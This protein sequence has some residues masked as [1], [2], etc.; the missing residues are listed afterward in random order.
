MTQ[1]ILFNKP[2]Q[3]LSQFTCNESD[4]ETLASFIK[5]PGVYAAGRLDYDSEGLLL[6]T[7]NGQLQH[8]IAH[9]KHKSVKTYWA[10]V[11]GTPTQDQIQQLC[12]GVMLKDGI[13][14]PAQVKAMDEPDIWKRVPPIR[15]RSNIP[16]TWLEIKIHEGRNRQV[17]RMTAAIN[18]PTLRLIRAAIGEWDISGLA[19]GEFK[20]VD[21]TDKQIE[22]SK[23][24]IKRKPP[25][26]AKGKFGK[27][28]TPDK[29]R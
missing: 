15:E 4:K 7:D 2:F 11:E 1:L 17:R 14:L 8:R 22:E 3:V 29:R 16:T 27:M 26:P 25:Y 21:L 28:R 6:L 13:T 23:P 19:P 24:K 20:K 12:K 10:Q 18:H 9:P 5:E